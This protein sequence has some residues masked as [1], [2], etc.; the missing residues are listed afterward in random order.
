MPLS[1]FLSRTAPLAKVGV[2]L[3][4]AAVVVGAQSSVQAAGSCPN[5]FLHYCAP[6]NWTT[7]IDGNG[8]VNFKGAPHNVV[9]T[10]ADDKGKSKNSFVTME[11]KALA[12]GLVSFDFKYFTKDVDGS[13]FDPFGYILNGSFNRLVPPPFLPKGGFTKG[14]FAFDVMAGDVFGFYAESV[15]SK[16]GSAITKV[17]NFSYT[18][19]QAVPGPVPF[20]GAAAAFGFSRRL[21]SRIRL[22]DNGTVDCA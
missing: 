3:S 11:L 6:E 16:L 18:H 15:D 21:K 14:S 8:S 12:D 10:S 2:F 1:R 4:L 9:L 20:L 7:A 17:S 13:K 22:R 19:T 5:G